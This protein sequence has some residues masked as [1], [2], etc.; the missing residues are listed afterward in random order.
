MLFFT[1]GQIMNYL[2]DSS[3]DCNTASQ[4]K[5]TRIS[6]YC[7]DLYLNALTGETYASLVSTKFSVAYYN[8][9]GYNYNLRHGLGWL[10]YHIDLYFSKCKDY[11]ARCGLPLGL[12]ACWIP[13]RIA[14]RHWGQISNRFGTAFFSSS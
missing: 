9:R 8:P 4:T 2:D 13:H 5:F 1:W 6:Y 10:S 14:L 7:Q 3:S 12:A 11:G